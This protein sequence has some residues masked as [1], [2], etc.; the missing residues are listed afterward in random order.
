[1]ELLWFRGSVLGFR[2]TGSTEPAFLYVDEPK[3][4][5][6][7]YVWLWFHWRAREFSDV[8]A[9]YT[10]KKNPKDAMIA[11]RIL[12]IR[13][14]NLIWTIPG[15]LGYPRTTWQH[16]FVWRGMK[17]IQCLSTFQMFRGGSLHRIISKNHKPLQVNVLSRIRR[18][19][20]KKLTR[21]V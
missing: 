12:R 3:S 14:S 19:K 1:M 10:R 11:M 15:H 5:C 7:K 2:G 6:R 20:I 13:I 18:A 9:R 16:L 21:H 4:P 8:H 17:N